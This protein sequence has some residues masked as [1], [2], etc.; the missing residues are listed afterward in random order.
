MNPPATFTAADLS[1]GEARRTFEETASSAETAVPGW[2]RLW[3]P[4]G[5]WRPLAF[6]LCLHLVF[7][8]L[9]LPAG[10]REHREAPRPVRFSSAHLVTIVPPGPAAAARLRPAA[11]PVRPPEPPPDPGAGRVVPRRLPPAAASPRT[12]ETPRDAAR[13]RAGAA[14]ADAPQTGPVTGRLDGGGVV[15]SE[16]PQVGDLTGALVIRADGE[17]L[18]YNYYFLALLRKI[19]EYWEPPPGDWGDEVAAMV[20]FTVLRDGSVPPVSVEE[21]SGLSAFDASA[22]RA[23]TRAAPLPPLPQEY[24]GEQIVFHLRFVYGRDSGNPGRNP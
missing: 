21:P 10:R 4:S 7:S 20:R 18:G 22:M 24:Q 16:L 6:S 12:R 9:S 14:R 11:A 13:P 17:D 2:K 19:A 5:Y 15:R 3:T 1:S 8:L 23:V